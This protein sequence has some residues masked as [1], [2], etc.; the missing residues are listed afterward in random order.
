MTSKEKKMQAVREAAFALIDIGLY[1]DS[2]PDD[3]NALDYFNKYQQINRE[4]RCEYEETYGPITVSGV[5]TCD[6][7]TWTQDPWPWEGGCN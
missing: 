3:K 7:W 5:N 1:L 6:G 4:V 2:H